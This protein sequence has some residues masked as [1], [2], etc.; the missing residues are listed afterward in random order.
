MFLGFH[1]DNAWYIYKH[2][3]SQLENHP[4]YI[5]T[6]ECSHAPKQSYINPIQVFWLQFLKL[7]SC[8]PS[9]FSLQL[10]KFLQGRTNFNQ[11]K[12]F[13]DVFS[14]IVSMFASER[15]CLRKGAVF[16]C[17]VMPGHIV[18]TSAWK[19]S[20]KYFYLFHTEQ[21]A[22]TKWCI[23][24]ATV[25]NPASSLCYPNPNCM[26][27]QGRIQATME[28]LGSTWRGY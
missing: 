26:Q 14:P 5:G 15:D 18:G 6:T 10:P 24:S 2:L 21:N 12:N 17:P 9:L 22:P 20:W 4:G 1:H 11:V 28:E 13:H 23:C 25:K 3:S 27:G 8:G 16:T 19:S 7:F